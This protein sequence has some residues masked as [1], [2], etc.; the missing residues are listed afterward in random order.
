MIYMDN[1][2]T[3]WPKP[4]NVWDEV[5]RVGKNIGANPGRA[6]HQMAI[7]AGRVIYKARVA[8]ARLFHLSDP[9]RV[10]FTINAT[11]A[12]NLAILGTVKPGDHVITSQLEHNAVARPLRYLQDKG[13]EVTYLPGDEYGRISPD[14]LRQSRKAN[15][16]TL[17]LSH[18]S[19]V[20]GALQDLKA[21]SKTAKELDLRVMVDA[22]QTAG[23]Q[24]IDM[25]EWGIDLLAFPGHKGLLGPQGT[26]GLCIAQGIDVDPLRFG[27]T[28]SQ[29]ESEFQPDVL[30]DRFESGT[31]NTPG[32]AG[33]A[34]GLEFIAQ[35]GREKIESHESKLTELILNGLGD[36]EKIKVYGPPVKEPRAAVISFN[37]DG[38][39]AA[40]MGF[41]L[42][43]VYQIAVRT[44]LHCAPVAHRK[45]GTLETGTV[46]LS[47]GYFNSEEEVRDVLAAIKTLV[48]EAR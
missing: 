20:T 32:I 4:D 25:E 29:S 1:A 14:E 31:P 47:P 5:L 17:I 19:N 40:E 18:A 6:G 27:G 2:A 23:V 39:E 7:D 11:E 10:I 46:R 9:L 8:I 24:Q 33:L 43:Q 16:K 3:T 38:M 13:V 26:G 42:D 41:L 22:A 45:N 36:L 15:T 28:G 44:G 21:L 12:L 48:E 30:P 37:V 34:A 35:T